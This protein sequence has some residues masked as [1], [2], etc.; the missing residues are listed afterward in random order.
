MTQFMDIC[1]SIVPVAS[2]KTRIPDL[3]I[4]GFEESALPSVVLLDN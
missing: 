2:K 1:Q 4:T 3:E